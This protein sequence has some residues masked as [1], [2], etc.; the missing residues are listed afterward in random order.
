MASRWDLQAVA[1]AVAAL[2]GAGCVSREAFQPLPPMFQTW[3]KEGVAPDGVK[4][5]LIE[6]GYENP[7]NGFDAR[8]PVTDEQLNKSAICMRKKGFRYLL[9][10]GFLVC[11]RPERVNDPSCK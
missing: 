10:G 6:C 7:F 2:C 1:L 11:D 8:T 4:Q 9:N 3:A 5:A